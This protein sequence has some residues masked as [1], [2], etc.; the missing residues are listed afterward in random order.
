MYRLILLNVAVILLFTIPAF[1]QTGA[2]LTLPMN[3]NV[4]PQ[5]TVIVPMMLTTDSLL[6]GAQIVIDFDSTKLKFVELLPGND[7]TG[8]S[9]TADNAL[10]FPPSVPGKNKN[11]MLTISANE[12][13]SIS[14]QNRELVQIKWDLWRVF[15]AVR[16]THGL[17]SSAQRYGAPTVIHLELRLRLF[18][19]STIKLE[20][21]LA[22]L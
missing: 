10:N 7:I 11:V 19:S 5:D 6:T 17:T 21:S 18:S 13:N 14:G 15:H 22:S 20:N 3:V 9:V 4:S 12:T 2:S 8:F 16:Q 1:A